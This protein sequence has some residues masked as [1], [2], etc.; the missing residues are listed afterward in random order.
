MN[1][2]IKVT[3]ALLCLISQSSYSQDKEYEIH[4]TSKDSVIA[5]SWH[6]GIGYNIIDDSGD[7]FDEL[8]SVSDQWNALP[9]PSRINIGRY[10][11]SGLGVEAIGSYNKYKVGKL[12]DGEIN[13]EEMD[14][15]AIDSRITYDLM[16]LFGRDSW[17]DPYIGVGLGYTSA[18]EEPRGTYNAVVGLRTWIT[19]K[20]ALDL[21]SSGKWRMGNIGTNHLQHAA[22]VVYRF[23]IEKELSQKGEERLAQIEALEEARQRKQD[24]LEAINRSEEALAQELARKK[25]LAEQKAI[26]EAKLAAENARKKRIVNEIKALGHVYF[27]LNSSYLSEDSKEVLKGLSNVM[28]KYPQLK[29]EISSHTDSRGTNEYNNW[30]SERRV[31]RTLKYLLT[32]G[33]SKERLQAQA[34]GEEELLNECDDTIYCDEEKHKVNR[35]SDFVI[36]KF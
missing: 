11:K 32:L 1:H 30:L 16:K 13:Q 8:F 9:Y 3:L 27:A 15:Y 20:I 24:S 18:R 29:L 10:F 14:Y 35:R 17:F 5:R 28:K 31:E 36:T 2:F 4:L 22:S 25:M 7:V 33:V 26:E 21:N 34:K 6:I 23:G 12:I 19:E